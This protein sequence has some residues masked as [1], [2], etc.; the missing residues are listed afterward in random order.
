MRIHGNIKTAYIFSVMP[1][2]IRSSL[3]TF[4]NKREAERLNTGLKNLTDL[5]T[6]EK[7]TILGQFVKRMLE[8]RQK[9][10][11]IVESSIL[12]G[13]LIL[14]ILVL[15]SFIY[16]LFA[17]RTLEDRIRCIESFLSGGGMHCAFYPCL[18]G[19]IMAEFQRRS[20]LILF[21]SKNHAADLL[22]SIPIALCIAGTIIAA[23]GSFIHTGH[24][25]FLRAFTLVVSTTIGPALE[26]LFFRMLL[27]LEAGKK[28]GYPFAGAISSILFTA[29]HIPDSAPLIAAYL[30][31]GAFLCILS[32]MRKG[33]FLPFVAHSLSN[34]IILLM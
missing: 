23:S 19:Y 25:I 24:D 17:Y 30:A 29:V 26:E 33:I 2:G 22:L 4:F 18:H 1:A 32:Y 6:G 3:L 11:I 13:F 20:R 7:K 31:S 16:S 14:G 15:A 9:R 5:S 27:F 8:L 28:L 12:Y 34:C 21:S 10:K